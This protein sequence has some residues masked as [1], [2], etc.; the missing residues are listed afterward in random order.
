MKSSKVVKIKTETY[1]KLHINRDLL[2]QGEKCKTNE[3][4]CAPKNKTEIQR[5]AKIL[6]DR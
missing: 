1:N 5:A 2:K 4:P 6:R 3:Q